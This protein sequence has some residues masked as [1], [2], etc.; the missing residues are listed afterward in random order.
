MTTTYQLRRQTSDARVA[1]ILFSQDFTKKAL[2]AGM[3]KPKGQ[4]K[5]PAEAE[6]TI[7]LIRWVNREGHELLAHACLSY[8]LAIENRPEEQRDASFID[9]I[10]KIRDGAKQ[11]ATAADTLAQQVRRHHAESSRD[12]QPGE[13]DPVRYKALLYLS[14]AVNRDLIEFTDEEEFFA[15]V[16]PRLIGGPLGDLHMTHGLSNCVRLANAAD[17]F[18]KAYERYASVMRAEA[19]KPLA[20][21]AGRRADGDR[22]DFI[23]DLADIY[24]GGLGKRPTASPA[25]DGAP[26]PF[27]RFVQFVYDEL[28][29]Q[30]YS[31]G[32]TAELQCPSHDVIKKVLRVREISRRQAQ[33]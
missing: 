3:H 8:L 9:L 19:Q 24:V 21:R 12:G 27:V 10:R 30:S 13:I 4:S 11:V 14:R 23:T 6:P 15:R 18:L 17:C 22:E 33:A 2:V 7:E 28:D 26:S 1:K 20:M 5:G 32:Y 31:H 25:N 29:R 16:R